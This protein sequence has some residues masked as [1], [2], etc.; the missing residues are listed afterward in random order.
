MSDVVEL[1]ETDIKILNML[2]KNARTKLT[3]IAKE[4]GTTSVSI[5]NRIKKLREQKIITGSTLSLRAARIGLPVMATIGV[6][7]DADKELEALD[8]IKEQAYL[9]EPSQSIGEYDLTAL[10]FAKSITELDQM[11]YSLKEKHGARKV[12]ISVWSGVA[13]LNFANINLAPLKRQK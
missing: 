2:I 13:Q 3:D 11:A 9:V 1:D 6:N 7:I 4:C 12:T 8:A 5:L 10:V